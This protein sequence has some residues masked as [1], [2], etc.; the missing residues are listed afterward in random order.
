MRRQVFAKPANA[1][2]VVDC[3]RKTSEKFRAKVFAYCVM[4]DH[5][6]LLSCTP[7]GIGFDTFVNVQAGGR[8]RAH[9]RGRVGQVWQP[10]YYD[11]ALRGYES[12][13]T[14]A[15]YIWGNPVR[16]GMVDAIGDYPWSGSLTWD[17]APFGV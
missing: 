14:L 17:G 6:H 8:L 12:L 10:R 5:V 15:L 1:S 3:L 2:A 7:G 4:P 9:G 11:H 13:S 16:A